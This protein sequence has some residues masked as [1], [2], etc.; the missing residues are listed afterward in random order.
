MEKSFIVV[1]YYTLNTLY[2][3]KAEM[4][5][6]TLERHGIPHYIQGVDNLGDWFANTSY[7]PTFLK[8][9]LAKFPECDIVYV[10]VD[11]EFTKYPSLFDTLGNQMKTDIAVYVFDR[12]CYNKSRG[13]TEVLSGT[14]YLKN[15]PGAKKIIEDWEKRTQS[16]KSE[17]DQK[18]L[19]Y[20]LKGRF[21]L[22]PGSYCKIFDRMDEIK[23]PVIVHYQASRIVRK[24]KGK[25]V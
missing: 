16:H 18:S 17:W 11:A 22:L 23:N 25:L 10:D 20:I 4:L 19:E 9:M 8:S 15:T 12:S 7:K 24:N 5:R 14:I 21:D 13:G 6:R 1:A 2:E 3:T